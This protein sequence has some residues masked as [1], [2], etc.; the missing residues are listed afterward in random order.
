MTMT[1]KQYSA[2]VKAVAET[3]LKVEA[4]VQG[5]VER[6]ERGE[7]FRFRS[8]ADVF[9][10]LHDT[11]YRLSS[12]LRDVEAAWS[13]RNWSFQDYQQAALVAQNID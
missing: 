3:L 13:R 7:Q 6:Y 5:L 8:T 9:N 10:A 11:E 12:E 1:R 2:K 4:K